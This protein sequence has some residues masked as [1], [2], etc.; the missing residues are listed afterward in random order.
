MRSFTANESSTFNGAFNIKGGLYQQAKGG[1][2]A[3]VGA[4]VEA[5]IVTTEIQG[6]PKLTISG[7]IGG[8]SSV[9]QSHSNSTNLTSSLT[10]AGTWEPE[11][12]ILNPVVGRRFIQNNLGIAI[13]KSATADLFM[14]AL[15]GT[16]TPVGYTVVPNDQIP[17]DTNI[18]DFPINPKYVK[19]GTLDGKVGL[20]NDPDYP[21]ANSERGSYFKPVEAYALKRSIEKEEQQIEAYYKQFS[22]N[23]YRVIGSLGRVK[24]KLKENDAYDFGNSRNQRSLYNTYVWTAVGGQS[25]E[26]LSVANSYSE[27][28]TGASSLK[29]GIGAEIKA[30]VGTPAGGYYIEADAMLGNT[31]TMPATKSEATS[32][33][34]QLL[35][36]V[37]PTDFLAAPKL[38]TG[39][40]GQLLFEG[41]EAT[42]APGKV[43]AYR[44]MS[45]LLAP[46]A[47]NFTALNQV[48]D[49]NWLNNSTTASANAMREALNDPT[50]PWRILYRTTYVSR[51]P[52][53]FQPVKDD[54]NAPNITPPAN[55]PSNVWLVQ[56]I[57]DQISSDHPTPL[58]I[59]AAIDTVLGDP[60]GGP[61]LLKTL[62]PWWSAFYESAQAYGT[63]DFIELAELR[64]DLLDYMVSKYEAEAYRDS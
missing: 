38:A 15:K 49:P 12:N 50:E 25:K 51:V 8:T 2:S 57:D 53:P 21:N 30:K 23:K 39:T 32:N 18:I 64:I 55:L 14:M 9:A 16:Q 11:V 29:F 48:V 56:I 43:D 58:E 34:F 40:D 60:R 26:E 17:V 46:K 10:P 31:W 36:N 4:E 59:G 61:G 62:I 1:T 22:V 5:E 42:A 28:Y 44:Y 24:D 45:F 20:V 19:N 52:A 6:G 63:E 35:A 47:E 13:V 37:A 7:D 33:G 41:Y 27:T 3:G 54:T